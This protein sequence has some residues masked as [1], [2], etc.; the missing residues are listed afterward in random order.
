MSGRGFVGTPQDPLAWGEVNIREAEVFNMQQKARFH[1]IEAW[2]GIMDA[3]SAYDGFGM[4]ATI[5]DY[6]IYWAIIKGSSEENYSLLEDLRHTTSFK[7]VPP[8]QWLSR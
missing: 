1:N 3:R 6:F 7:M 2:T 4:L 8:S 5:G